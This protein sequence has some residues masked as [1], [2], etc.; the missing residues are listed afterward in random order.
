LPG[1]AC[2]GI[3]DSQK[4]FVIRGGREME[5]HFECLWDLFHS[6]P[7]LE[8]PK[9]S[10]LDEFYRLNKVDP[11]SS[12]TRATANRGKDAHTDGK[13][14]LSAKASKEIMKFFLT[15]DELMYDKK[16]TDFFTEDFLD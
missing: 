5:D 14:G 16:I 10:V 8:T 9:T 2:D 3:K 4:G 15:S 13:F 7:S 11:N 1:G 6:I 12:L